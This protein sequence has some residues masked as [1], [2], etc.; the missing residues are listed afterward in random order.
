MNVRDERGE[1][2]I[3]QASIVLKTSAWC[4]LTVLAGVLCCLSGEPAAAQPPRYTPSRPTVSPY[5]NLL[6]NDNGTMPNY[7][8]LVRPQ[9]DQ[10]AFDRQA[11]QNSRMNSIAIRKLESLS[12]NPTGAPTGSGSTFNNLSHYYPRRR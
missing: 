3:R 9:L 1:A 7:Y 4:R 11:T 10:Q 6:R 12:T 5:L 8:S 2:M